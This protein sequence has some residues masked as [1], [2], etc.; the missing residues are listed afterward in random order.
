MGCLLAAMS[1]MFPRAVLIIFWIARPEK[2]DAVFSSFLWPVLG[3]ILLPFA[4]LMYVF[5]SLPGV[6]T[7]G[8]DWGW[9]ALAA[10]FDVLHSIF[11]SSRRS[12][13]P[14]PAT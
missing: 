3:I 9:V 8:T 7:T 12:S 10:L 5:L 4:T 13:I 6:G 11:V 14:L 1:A 2:V